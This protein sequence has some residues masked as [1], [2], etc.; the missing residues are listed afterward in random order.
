MHVYFLYSEQFHERWFITAMG[1]IYAMADR[2]TMDAMDAMADKFTTCTMDPISGAMA[3]LVIT[4]ISGIFPAY[5]C[6]ASGIY[7]YYRLY[8]QRG[9]EHD[10]IR[11]A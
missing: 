5:S 7:E 9:S 10:C 3:A 11:Y 2:Y 4:G 1:T 6:Y 8:Y